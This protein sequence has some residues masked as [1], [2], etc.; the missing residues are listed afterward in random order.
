MAPLD[1]HDLLLERVKWK[2]ATNHLKN[3]VDLVSPQQND[4]SG[5]VAG[6]GFAQGDV[7]AHDDAVTGLKVDLVVGR[8][9][10]AFDDPA[11]PRDRALLVLGRKGDRAHFALELGQLLGRFMLGVE[12]LASLSSVFTPIAEFEGFNPLRDSGKIQNLEAALLLEIAG[13]IVLVHPLHGQNNPRLFLV[14]ATRKKG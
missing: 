13:Q 1:L 12:E 5:I 7:P 8:Q 3:V 10:L 4:T 9:P 2:T 11:A 6:F 14:V